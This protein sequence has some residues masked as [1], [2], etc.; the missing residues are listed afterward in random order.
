MS[1][2]L[3]QIERG[4]KNELP[5]I[6][7]HIPLSPTGRKEAADILRKV[8]QFRESA[9][10][11][12]LYEKDNQLETI[13]MQRPSYRG[14]HSGE[15]CFPGG[16]MDPV[17][18]TLIDT[19]RREI[20]EEIG[21]DDHRLN[22]MGQL[23]PVYIPVS[24]FKVQPYVFYYTGQPEFVLDKREVAEVF[25]FPSDILLNDDIIKSTKLVL[26]DKRVLPNVPYFDINKKIVWGATALILNEFKVLI[27]NS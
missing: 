3:Q 18:K 2:T 17:D 14:V 4:L 10:G 16:K 19:V 8:R 21:L 20:H 23:T 12:I 13:L 1:I 11:L 25:T 22:L 5:G 15:V 24:L 6:S 7:A 26:D 9:V 27:E